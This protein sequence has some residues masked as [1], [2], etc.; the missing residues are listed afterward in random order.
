MNVEQ[1]EHLVKRRKRMVSGNANASIICLIPHS[2]RARLLTC[3]LACL[4]ARPVID[5][6][7][8]RCLLTFNSPY[9]NKVKKRRK[10]KTM[11]DTAPKS[12]YNC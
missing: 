10:K 7:M 2:L 6:L 4:S 5:E 9:Q 11:C 8:R 3:L 1:D 12:L